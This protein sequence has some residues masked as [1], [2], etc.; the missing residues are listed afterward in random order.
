MSDRL[1]IDA[2]NTRVKWA[3]LSGQS[4]WLAQGAAAYAA[5]GE[6]PRAAAPD[7]QVF[8]A[9]VASAEQETRLLD[10]LRCTR[11]TVHWLK[12]T[13]AAGGVV[14]GYDAPAQLGVDRWLG[15][16]AARQRTAGAALV[17]S[18]GTALVVDALDAGGRFLGGT[19]Q[20]G[21][22][23][24]RR[25]LEQGL[26]HLPATRGRL[27]EFPRNTADAVESGTVRALCASIEQGHARLCTHAAGP[28]SCLL[29]G[30][31][32]PALMPLL[33]LPCQHVPALVLEGMDVLTRGNGTP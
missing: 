29:T 19:I 22:A 27:V 6:L 17:V 24:M 4:T 11:E 5:L 8:V 3:L 31:D 1:L 26:A 18:A 9:S 12:S 32:A 33:S 14:N 10:A 15:L 30:G 28:V 7:T 13:P 16:V 25:A 23:L 21:L 20:P 2:G